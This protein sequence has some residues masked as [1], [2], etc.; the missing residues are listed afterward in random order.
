MGQVDGCFPPGSQEG[1]PSC[2]AL[3][4]WAKFFWGRP[5]VSSAEGELAVQAGPVNT[6]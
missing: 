1:L 5:T 3:K 4:V 6:C 2:P